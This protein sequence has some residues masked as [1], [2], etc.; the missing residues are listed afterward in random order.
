MKTAKTRAQ[1]YETSTSIS[2]THTSIGTKT[3]L[4]ARAR[5]ETSLFLLSSRRAIP[6]ERRR[7]FSGLHCI[8]VLLFIPVTSGNLR[9]KYAMITRGN[10]INKYV[11]LHVHV[12]VRYVDLISCTVITRTYEY[13]KKPTKRENTIYRRVRIT[14][15]KFLLTRRS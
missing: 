15:I 14:R 5:W 9:N 6:H 7:C 3:W 10:E 1:I 2:Y 13:N 11:F 12:Y 8:E 4:Q